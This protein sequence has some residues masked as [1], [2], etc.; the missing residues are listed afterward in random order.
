MR[1]RLTITIIAL[2][3]VVGCEDPYTQVAIAPAATI[4]TTWTEI[5]LEKPIA[6]TKPVEEFTFHIDSPHQRNMALEILAPDG[7][8]SVPE[9]DFVA[10]DG[11]VIHLDVHGFLN[12]DMFFTTQTP[13]KR[14]K[15][16]RMRNSFQI[17]ISNLRWVG[18]DPKEVKR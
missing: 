10:D 14:A 18:Y 5:H 6:W 1:I 12:D 8:R 16:I 4:S 7:Q 13:I 17:H 11:R 15:A 9:V 3:A 2:C